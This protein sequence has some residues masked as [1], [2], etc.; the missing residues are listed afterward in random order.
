M[1][2]DVVTVGVETPYRSIVDLL[3]E[4]R[5]SG[6]PVIDDF[7]RVR[8]VV[9]ESD[10]L[11]KVELTGQPEA[12]LFGS[13]RSRTA[14][15]HA[16]AS[17]A[18]QLMSAPAVTVLRGT[19]LATAARLMDEERI[20]RLPV[21]DELGRLEGIVSRRD[22]L[23]VYLRPDADIRAD[24]VDGVV[25]RVLAIEEG[26]IQVAIRDGVV[27]LDGRLDRRSTARIAVH[28]VY[29]VPGV[30]Q[31]TDRLEYDFDDIQLIGTGIIA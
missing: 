28:L 13:R 1:S 3:T 29:G 5:I 25:R 31:V 8:G 12:R 17:V 20:K 6:V 18:E 19:P 24:V 22:L 27:T 15:S 30:V 23:K 26:L 10:L 4:H 9:S 2:T 16:A 11:A 14:R 21:I 7:D